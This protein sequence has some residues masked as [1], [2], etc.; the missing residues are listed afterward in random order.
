MKKISIIIPILNERENI[1]KLVKEI[2]KNLKEIKK[3]FKFEIIFVDDNSTDGTHKILK[4]IQNNNIRYYI[5][6][7]KPDL[8]QSCILG[9]EKATY[10]N[11]IVMDGDL[12]H[13]PRYIPK[14]VNLFFSR[15][16][17]FVIC[18][19]DFTKLI[20][21]SK[22]FYISARSFLSAVICFIFNFAV[23]K[24]VKDPMSGYFMFKKK[25]YKKNKKNLFAKGYKILADLLTSNSKSFKLFNLKINFN[26][27]KKNKSKLNLKILYL[28]ILF[29]F[30]RNKLFIKYSH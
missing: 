27:R 22:N 4:Q 17:D 7:K 11:I 19:R 16:L 23:L 24:G 10:D 15:N 20:K 28:I 21:A 3:N 2:S 8:S 12:Q 30:K 29:L 14:M 25:I 6:K 1:K 26:P 18:S 5:R 9:F 13:D